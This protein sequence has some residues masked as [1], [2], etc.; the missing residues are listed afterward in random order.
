MALGK[1]AKTLT[2]AQVDAALGYLS[3]TRHAARNRVVLQLSARPG[4]GPRR[5][6]F[7]RG[8]D[9]GSEGEVG[10]STHHL[11]SASKD[12]TGGRVISTNRLHRSPLRGFSSH[13]GR[14]TFI[15]VPPGRPDLSR[16]S[17]PMIGRLFFCAAGQACGRYTNCERGIP[18]RLLRHSQNG[19]R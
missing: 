17:S 5:S 6:P 8:H 11:N 12:R 4:S 18:P 13:S 2:K 10:N 3:N 16:R 1:Q 7:S 15:T 14:R 19:G 9:H